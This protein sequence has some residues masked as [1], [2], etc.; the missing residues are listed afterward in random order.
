MKFYGVV[1]FWIK[2]TEVNPGVWKSQI[3]ER[4]YTGDILRNNRKFQSADQQNDNFTISNQISI[5]AD[6]YARENLNSIRYVVWNRVAWKVSSVEINYPR[7]T[8]ELGGVYNGERPVEI[9]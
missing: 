7:I 5:L 6:L 2:E 4:P 9:T 8:L 1:G 3:L